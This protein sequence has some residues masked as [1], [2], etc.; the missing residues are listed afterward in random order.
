MR[1]IKII[2]AG[3]T[4]LILLSVIVV[5]AFRERLLN[6]ML[7]K[8][9]ASVER[10]YD[11]DIKIEKYGFEGLSSVSM[12]G[13]SVVPFQRDTLITVRDFKVSVDI[14]PILFGHIKIASLNT[15]GARLW[16]TNRNGI[17]NFD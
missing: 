13:I 5:F 10:K 12:Q 4:A 14:L 2:I 17:R 9:I 3:I 16:L 15:H 7:E 8:A 6:K 11:L 1:K